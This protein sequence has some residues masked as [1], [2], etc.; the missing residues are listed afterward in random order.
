M[1]QR[2][3]S[4]VQQISER[5]T[6][7]L[8]FGV[9]SMVWIGSKL[10]F[11][12]QVL[13]LATKQ[14][15]GERLKRRAFQDYQPTRHDV[16][17]CTYA[18]SGTNWM[19]Q[20]AYQIA[21]RGRG[22]YT[23]IHH[24]VPWPEAPMP[25]IV[26]LSDEHTYR[27][28]PTGLRVIKT[29][30]ESP[31]VPY[32]PE[33][34]YIVVVRDPKDVLVS[35]YHFSGG[36]M[37]GA[38]VPMDEWLTMFLTSNFQYGS[39]TEHLASYWPWRNRRNVLVL[40]FEEMKQDLAGSVRRIAHLMEVELSAEELALVVEKSSFQYMK[41]IDHKFVPQRPFPFNRMG[42]PVMIRKGE[43]GA[44]SE[45]LTCKQQAQIDRHIRAELQQRECDF[46]YDSAF[47]VVDDHATTDV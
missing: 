25:R 13:A 5:L 12:R 38:M 1:S 32:S 2:V 28:A 43:R 41:Q 3:K 19:M 22:E 18:K 47:T 23:H 34:K 6:R 10:G 30:L 24:V 42:K 27:A 15:Q 46:P 17:V 40:T 14:M 4:L 44:A 29:H 26:K 8:L 39:W 21:H 9:F 20:I 7:A 33:A 11:K 36:L 35:S 16:F 45:L 37:G 31:Y